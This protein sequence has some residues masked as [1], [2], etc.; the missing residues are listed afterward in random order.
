M[1]VRSLSQPAC[2]SFEW[3][4]A[5]AVGCNGNVLRNVFVLPQLVI[6]GTGWWSERCEKRSKKVLLVNI[7]KNDTPQPACF[8]RQSGAIRPAPPAACADRLE[9]VCWSGVAR[10]KGDEKIPKNQSTAQTFL[11]TGELRRQHGKRFFADLESRVLSLV[12]GFGEPREWCEGFSQN[13]I[14]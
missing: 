4:R 3:C 6:A 9:M 2:F 13:T 10:L 7:S 1:L 11:C 5:N 12:H 8:F 14:M